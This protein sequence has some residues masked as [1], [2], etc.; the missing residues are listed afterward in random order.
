MLVQLDE[1]QRERGRSRCIHQAIESASECWPDSIA[2]VCGPEQ[3]SFGEL[4]RRANQLGRYL[5]ALGVGPEVRVGVCLERS[6]EMVVAVLG[7]L[8]AGGAYVP[9]DPAHPL[10]RMAL[11]LE[12]AGVALLLTQE[13]LE[14]RL[15]ADLSHTL[16]IDAD[17]PSIAQETG[18]NVEAGVEP[19]HAAYVIYTSG[20]TGRPK[21][22]VIE[23]RGVCNLMEAQR[24]IFALRTEDRVFQF[25]SL[26]FDASVW[27][28][29]A[30][31]QSGATLC[32]STAGTWQAGGE[33][34]ELLRQ[35]MITMVTLPPSVLMSM[36]VK[37]L[38]TLERVVAAGEAC[39]SEIVRRWAE[40]RRFFNAYGPTE[41][42]VCATVA[43]CREAERNPSIGRAIANA[44][45][46][47]LNQQ[48]ESAAIGAIGELYIG[49]EGI[50]R[51]YLNRP[52]R[53]AEQFLPDPL[54]PTHGGRLYKT[55]D[56]G[57]LRENG[58]I[59]YVGRVDHQVKIRGY[60]IELGEIETVLRQHPAVREAVASASDDGAGQHRLVAYVVEREGAT[61]SD[62]QLREYMQKKVAEYMIPAVF[63]RLD[64]MPLTQ[65][66]K[67]DRSKLPSPDSQR[68]SLAKTY[69]APRNELERTIAAIWQEVLRLPDVGIHDNFFEL[70]GDSLLMVQVHSLLTE[71]VNTNISI[72]ELFQYPSI[73]SLAKYMS[74]EPSRKPF[75]QRSRNRAEMRRESMRRRNEVGPS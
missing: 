26:S 59:E 54:S 25:A 2:V 57:R 31:L 73:N 44:Q 53:T 19:H 60:R 71:A 3:M 72:M 29:F 62:S 22:V 23:H 28:I 20:S 36:P 35:E 66:G 5:R 75:V 15:P 21:G 51:G 30:T 10:E 8:K 4:N 43:E 37:S 34:A 52:E 48:M 27:E 32:L 39:T 74:Q 47:V 14:E 58:D 18:E 6:V 24:Q 33:L 49:G 68:P 12:D 40:G 69:E 63:V 67:I 17:W 70:G 64:A 42:T 61:A 65:N 45:V 16:R 7:V 11:M 46:Y 56:L 13:R 38:P 41:A 9:L 50:A 55:G 1:I